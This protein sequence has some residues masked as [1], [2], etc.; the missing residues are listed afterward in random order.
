MRLV[1]DTN[2]LISALFWRG[3]PHRIWTAARVGT[4]TPIISEVLLRE[5]RDVLTRETGPFKLT[6]KEFAKVRRQV[7]SNSRVIRP[8]SSLSILDD[9][10]D[11][12]VLECALD[13]KAEAIVTG[14]VAM[15]KLREYRR[16]RILT[17]RESW[18]KISGLPTPL[19]KSR[20]RR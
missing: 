9:E 11:N 20:K 6:K 15:R 8:R 5:L 13:G 10:P 4:V 19:R 14:D 12:R 7:R 2:V 18:R 16:I 17:P 3:D 1:L